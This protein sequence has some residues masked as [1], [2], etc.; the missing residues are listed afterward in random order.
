MYSRSGTLKFDGET[1]TESIEFGTQNQSP[2][3]GEKAVCKIRFEDNKM[4]VS[5][6]I[7]N[8]ISYNEVWERVE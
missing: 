2:F 1:Y 3:F 7:A 8:N 6:V 4:Y 5:G